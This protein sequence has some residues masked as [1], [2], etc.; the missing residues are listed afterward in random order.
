MNVA[1][2][3][4]RSRLLHWTAWAAAVV[5]L[6]M[7]LLVVARPVGPGLTPLFLAL[8][9]AFAVFFAFEFFTRTGW[10]QSRAAYLRWRWFDFL[11]MVP[12]LAVPTGF[13][14]HALLFWVVLGC[15]AIRATDRTL[16]DG[17][18]QRNLLVVLSVLEE[19]ISDR[20]ILKIIGRIDG[21]LQRGRF[22]QAA[23]QAMSQ[24]KDAVLKRI[25]DEQLKEGA[26][27]RF[28]AITGLKE[29]LE[30]A[31]RKMFDSIIEVVGSPEM[32]H[33]IRDVIGASLERARQEI[34]TKSSRN[35]FGR[36]RPVS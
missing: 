12:V 6:A 35:R 15:R 33:A 25:Y 17:F 9:A 5:T 10:R 19:E 30:H 26:V 23:A 21:E 8:D 29:A 18:V 14:A 7:M 28:A 13:P 22:G 20:V 3:R 16:G 32:D 31:E 27:A 2:P 36:S 1:A 24:N 4:R 11:A 34:G